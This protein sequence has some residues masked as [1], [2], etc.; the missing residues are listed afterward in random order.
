MNGGEMDDIFH[1]AK[2]VHLIEAAKLFLMEVGKTKAVV[3]TE[4]EPGI[5][6]VISVTV[7]KAGTSIARG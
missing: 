1:E 6:M 7:T 4:I 2:A 5:E 3:R